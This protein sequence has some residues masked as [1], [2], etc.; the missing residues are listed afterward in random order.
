MAAGD[1]HVAQVN[2]ATLRAPIDS[3]QL[4]DFVALLD[5]IN[6]LADRTPGFVWRLQTEDGDATAIRAFPDERIIVN[7]SVWETVEALGG[8]VY[9]SRHLDV[10]RRRRAWF[11]KMATSHLALWWIPAGT[12]P[13]VEQARARLD[14]LDARGSSPEAFTLREPFPPP[15]SDEPVARDE[16]GL[17]PAW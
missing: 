5:P 3:P 10:L 9:A 7:L 6:A 14:L 15:G 11:E 16:R 2:I 17:S 4:A 12:T 8:F 1:W 13:T